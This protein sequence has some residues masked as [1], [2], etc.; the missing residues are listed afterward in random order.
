MR[1]QNFPLAHHLQRQSRKF[2]IGTGL[3]PPGLP[4][5]LYMVV[6]D[7]K[8]LSQADSQILHPGTRA[9]YRY[10]EMI[11]TENAAPDR[12]AL[13]LKP[14]KQLV[15]NLAILERDNLRHSFKWRLAG[16]AVGALFRDGLTGQDALAHWDSFER[17][18]VQTLYGNVVTDLQPCL[19]RFRLSTELGTVIGAEQVGLPLLGKNQAQIQILSGIFTFEDLRDHRHERITGVELS[20]ARMIWTEHLPGDKLVARLRRGQ[21]HPSGLTLI[22]GGKQR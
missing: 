8:D 4:R 11:R 2:T 13:D 19:L 14:I 16:T 17:A 10:W 22:P 15:A 9:L 1:P 7:T 3:K 5:G 6:N 20:G 12:N 21:A 18:T